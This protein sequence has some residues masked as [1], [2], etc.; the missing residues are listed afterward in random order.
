MRL[1]FFVAVLMSVVAHAEPLAPKKERPKKPVVL[2]PIDV[3]GQRQVPVEIVIPRS[4][5]ARREVL[6]TGADRIQEASGKR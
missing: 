1:A 2:G 3:S 4:E 5:D 6:E